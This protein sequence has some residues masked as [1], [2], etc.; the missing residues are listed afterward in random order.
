MTRK[1]ILFITACTLAVS[2]FAN[3]IQLENVNL[4]GQN[5]TSKFSLVGF[6]V[7]WENSW[8]LANNELNWDAA[9]I[10]VKYRKKGA[11]G[12]QHATLNNTGHT[13]GSGAAITSSPDGKGAFIFRSAP[14]TGNVNF[15]GNQ[16]RWNY[17]VDGVLDSDSVEVN[18][19][20]TEM[21][22][23]TAGG[24]WLG[25]NGTEMAHFRRGDKD[26]TYWVGSENQINIGTSNTTLFASTGAQGGTLG[27]ISAAYPKGVN[28]FYIMKYEVSEGQYVDFLNNLDATR[29]ANRNIG[30]F[31][32]TQPNLI[33][34][35]PERA[36]NGAS[37]EDVMAFLDWSALRP[38]TEFEYEKASRGTNISPIPN[39]YVW[40][41]TTITASSGVLD[42]GLINETVTTGNTNYA[43]SIQ[44]PLR[45]G[46]FATNSSSRVSSGGT[47]FGVMEMSGNVWEPVMTAGNAAGR[48]FT[49]L[50]GDGNLANDGTSDMV[51]GTEVT[52]GW[53]YRGGGYN[54]GPN[55][56]ATSARFFASR[57][58]FIANNNR[59]AVNGIR[60][61]RTAQ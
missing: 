56:L 45:C 15:P 49:G 33:S 55:N 3:N 20:A 60:G 12:W 57:G 5:T 54:E 48:T 9:W 17:G 21:V 53:G 47:Y 16:L 6:D 34:A 23:V 43:N 11:S 61:V 41:N 24:F 52:S 59:I 1:I 42:A 32:G 28:A 27:T 7:N 4:N 39:E 10:F 13:P 58:A 2:L 31:T 38:M 50:H 30:G 40:G 19:Y 36:A 51:N 37:L 35:Q 25:S 26:T 22:Y 14:G 29:A 8:R 18:V 44:R 46:V